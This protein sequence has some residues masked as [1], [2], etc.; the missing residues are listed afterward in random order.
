[1]L[2]CESTWHW[3][4]RKCSLPP[5]RH[6]VSDG[7]SAHRFG[8]ALTYLDYERN[9]TS[10]R[11]A[12]PGIGQA[13]RVKL[14]RWLDIWPTNVTLFVIDFKDPAQ[15]L[16]SSTLKSLRKYFLQF[17]QHPIFF[18][19]QTLFGAWLSSDLST[20]SSVTSVV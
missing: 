13:A 19:H 15:C 12:I 11:L 20:R 18:A 7:L 5:T 1:M 3:G 16:V 2:W 4:L 6:H 14:I 10:C 17:F 8:S 9:Q